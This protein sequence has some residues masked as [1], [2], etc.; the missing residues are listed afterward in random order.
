MQRKIELKEKRRSL[1]AC[2]ELP[3][4]LPK[5]LVSVSDSADKNR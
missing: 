4:R 1:I 5:I 2:D 3:D